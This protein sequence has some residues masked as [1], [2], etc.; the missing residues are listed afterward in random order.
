[1]TALRARQVD[2]LYAFADDRAANRARLD[3]ARAALDAAALIV[4]RREAAYRV[5][6]D[7]IAGW[8]VGPTA[9]DYGYLWS[10]R[11]LFFWW[12]D[13][14][15]AVDRPWSP[16][17]LNIVDPLRVAFGEGFWIPLADGARAFGS[18]FGV[19]S[20]TDLL[21]SP[22][23]EPTFPQGGLRQRP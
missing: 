2:G 13:E 11:R 8:R 4:T 21:A 23:A 3:D 16:A 17:Y 15:K 9:Y 5:P 14:G 20:V 7:R 22:T 10:V 6:A 12:R 1:V 19:N 18:V